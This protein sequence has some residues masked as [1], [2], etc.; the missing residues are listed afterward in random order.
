MNPLFL[1]VDAGATKTHAVI[2]NSKGEVLGAGHSGCGSHEVAGYERARESLSVAA[3]RALYGAGAAQED[4]RFAAFCLAGID[5]RLDVNEVSRRML[6]PLMGGVPYL[7]KNDAFGCLRGG[8]RDP[9]GV[10]INC[11]TGQVAVGRNRAGVEIRVGGYGWDF[12]D[13]AGGGVISQATLAAIVRADDGRGEPTQLV[14]R[15]LSASGCPNVS[16]FIERGYRDEEFVRNLE[17]PR[18]TFK[19]SKQGDPV[20]RRIILAIA[21]EMAV[22]AVTLIRRLGMEQESFDV[23]T[24]GSV[25]KGEDPVFLEVIGNKVHET[26]PAATL[27][28][29]LYPPV[30]GCALLALE[31]V[32]IPVGDETYT[33]IELSL[34]GKGL[35]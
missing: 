27:R 10:M 13:F 20:A 1:G 23:I 21:D 3:E 4:L 11:G 25:F 14:E 12:G 9:F 26:A 18:I 6:D 30:V 22:T 19:A 32:G 2:L 7:L 35:E 24:A 34:N 29:P 31:S 28:M 17:L 33:N 15:V 16:E 5:I 8:T